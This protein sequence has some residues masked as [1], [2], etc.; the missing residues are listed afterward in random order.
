[1]GVIILSLIAVVIGYTLIFIIEHWQ[2]LLVLFAIVTVV[3]I[4]A[5]IIDGREQRGTGAGVNPA[6]P[7]RDDSVDVFEALAVASLLPDDSGTKKHSGRCDGDCANCPPHYGY[8]YGRWYY[9]R[10]HQ[11]G[12]Q[13]GGN[14]GGGRYD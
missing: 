10:C 6:P 8:R 1:M 3:L 2:I 11:H 13:F 4:V 7:S 5:A 14:C 12:C 9:G